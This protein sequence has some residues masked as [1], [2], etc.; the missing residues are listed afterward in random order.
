MAAEDRSP[1]A[2][3]SRRSVLHARASAGESRRTVL[4]ALGSNVIVTLA[5]LA[6]GLLSGSAAMLAETAHSV[7]DTTNQV[8]LYVSIH[9][10]EREPTPDQPFGYARARFLWTF[11]AAVAM[12]LAGAVFAIGYGIYELLSSEPSTGHIAAYVSLA[13]ALVAEGSSW[14]RALAQTRRESASAQ[15]SL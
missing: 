14:L 13:I 2:W 1:S 9:L 6:A 12:F 11:L 5:K 3:T 8:F 15:L 10:A 4:V 7:A